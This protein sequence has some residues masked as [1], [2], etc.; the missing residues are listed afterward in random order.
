MSDED[1]SRIWHDNVMRMLK[2]DR[3]EGVGSLHQ[4]DSWG[5]A[6]TDEAMA[7]A[8]EM[9]RGREGSSPPTTSSIEEWSTSWKSMYFHG[10]LFLLYM[11][12][13]GE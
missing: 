2:N 7:V 13:S 10:C 8:V 9:G 3:A 4:A 11:M 1:R 5:M 12:Q 6:A